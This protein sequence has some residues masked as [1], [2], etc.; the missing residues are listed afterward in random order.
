MSY[1]ELHCSYRERGSV[2]ASCARLLAAALLLA[3]LG[4]ALAD[5]PLPANINAVLED[6]Q[7]ANGNAPRYKM[8]GCL[9]EKLAD[10]DAA[11]KKADK[12]ARQ[13]VNVG[14]SASPQAL[15]SL[16]KAEHAFRTFRKAEC[17]R[18]GRYSG[19]MRSLAHLLVRR[20]TTAKLAGGR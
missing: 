15:K 10:A 18:R 13:A 2:A 11:V 16:T 17:Q 12:L 1:S 20:A 8:A 4:A 5:T 14:S 19:R 3:P 7:R 6:C 9:Q